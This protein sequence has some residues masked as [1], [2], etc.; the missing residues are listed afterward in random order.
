LFRGILSLQALAHLSEE[1]Q[2]CLNHAFK[3]RAMQSAINGVLGAKKHTNTDIEAIFTLKAKQKNA[4]EAEKYNIKLL[5]QGYM[6]STASFM[7]CMSI[8]FFLKW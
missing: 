2:K 7:R 3:E 4:P 5:V 8:I 1:G 6:H